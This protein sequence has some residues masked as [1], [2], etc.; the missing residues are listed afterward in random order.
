MNTDDFEKQLQRQPIRPVPREW[1][2]DILRAAAKT[3]GSPQP[4][5]LNSQ[6]SS[7]WRELLW[8]CPQAWAGLAAVWVIIL[9]LNSASPGDPTTIA[10]RPASPA[11]ETL[12]AL[13][14]QRRLLAELIAPVTDAAEPTRAYVPR[15]RSET[16]TLTKLA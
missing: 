6:P 8:P 15:P 2:R 5:T 1:R 9:T 16:P 14:E 7:W 13:R 10:K 12:L 4:S 11:P 3:C